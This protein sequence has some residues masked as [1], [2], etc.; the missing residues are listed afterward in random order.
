MSDSVKKNLRIR[1]LT[2]TE[3]FRLMGVKDIDSKKLEPLSNNVKYHL[4]GDSIVVTVLQAIFK[5][6]LI[7]HPVVDKKPIRLIELFAG[8]GS[9]SLALKYLGIPYESYKICEWAIPSI[10]AYKYI[11]YP[12]I[13]LDSGKNF[14]K[15]YLV[16]KL[17]E[18]GVSN[19]WN[20]PMKYDSLKRKGYDY[21]HEIYANIGITHNLVDITKVHAKDLDVREREKYNYI[22]T[23][24]FPCFVAG[25]LI[26]TERGLV[27]IEDIRIGNVV[28]THDGTWQKVLNSNCTGEKEVYQIRTMC[29]GITQCTP[30]H[31]FYV[32]KKYH[33]WNNTRRSYDRM[34][35]PPVYKSVEDLYNTNP[36]KWYCGMPINTNS[37]IPKWDGISFDWDNTIYSHKHIHSNE[38]SKIIDRE[39]FWWIVG[40]WVA[41]G[42][43]RSQSGIIIACG[44]SEIED[45]TSRAKKLNISINITHDRT[46]ERVH[47]PR[48]EWSKFTEQFGHG[49]LHKY[50]P[51]FV[52]DLPVKLLKAFLDGYMSGDGCFSEGVYKA[53]SVSRKL[54]YGLVQIIAK[55]YHRPASVYFTKT[56]PTHIIEGRVVNQ[57]DRYSITWKTTNDIQDK[58]FYEDGYIWYPIKDI[59]PLHKI[60][61]V[62]DITVENSHSFV[63]NN[64]IVHNCQDISLAGKMEGMQKNSG[65]RSGLLWEVE[66]ILRESG[67]NL[68]QILLMENV[69]QVISKKNIAD[70]TE[71]CNFLE[72]IGYTNKYEILNAKEVGYPEPIPQN[73]KRCF[74]ISVLNP[75]CD[76]VFPNETKR[77]LTLKDMLENEVDEKYYLSDRFLNFLITNN[78]KQKEN[79]NGFR[80]EIKQDDSVANAVTT[81]A[82]G[83]MT[84]NFVDDVKRIGGISDSDKGKHQAVSVYDPNGLTHNKSLEETLAKNEIRETPTY[85]D[86]YN[87]TIQTDTSGTITT[88]VSNSN[89]TFVAIDKWSDLD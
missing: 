20:K 66:R 49:A 4:A 47:I 70:F 39:E 83:R 18:L 86:S 26:T 76:I 82:G 28:Q 77:R 58:A 68:P 43:Q 2:P 64:Q 7:D 44:E 21:L 31:L 75:K 63:A 30:N 29:G 23:Y 11:H 88:R 22:M 13:A 14:T 74:M 89:N 60:K 37:K 17:F 5:S 15:D 51:Q 1:K 12:D 9:Q 80:F 16:D 27:P 55:V 73:R 53:T 45:F 71:W 81:H 65:T 19:D 67:D 40:R 24:S 61:K 3:C 84:D 79:G 34:F 41:D 69:P 59:T 35:D 50:I 8:Y 33:K 85:I 56:N 62:Y 36:R 87:K 6:I 57:H 78:E 42:W 72:S 52:M 48:K 10:N 54:I 32:R 25:T 38:I 46:T